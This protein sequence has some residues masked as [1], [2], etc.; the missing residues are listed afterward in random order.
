VTLLG[1]INLGLLIGGELY[2]GY[3]GAFCVLQPC[4][5]IVRYPG[6][7]WSTNSYVGIINARVILHNMIIKSER[8]A[9]VN[10]G[11]PYNCHWVLSQFSIL[12]M[13]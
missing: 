3:R 1:R 11:H 7:S 12:L 6:L 10:D 5:A 9:L 4:F 2:E 13:Y 8:I